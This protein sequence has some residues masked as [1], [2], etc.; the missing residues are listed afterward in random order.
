MA[1]YKEMWDELYKIFSVARDNY[2]VLKDDKWKIYDVIC[3]SMKEMEESKAD[4]IPKDEYTKGYVD[5][6]INMNKN[7]YK[8]VHECSTCKYYTHIALAGGRTMNSY[9]C[10]LT[11]TADIC[12]DDFCSKWVK[13]KEEQ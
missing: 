5:A 9:F 7:G 3:L 1:D 11:K 8:T 4:K 2:K 6:I 13:H 10:S 12:S